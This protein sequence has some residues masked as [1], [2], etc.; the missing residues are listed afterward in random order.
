MSSSR[1]RLARQIS[2]LIE[3]PDWELLSD[4]SKGPRPHVIGVTG[5]PGAGKSTLVDQLIRRHVAAGD[6]PGVVVVDPSSPFTGGAIL[7]DRIRMQE[8]A[9]DRDVFIRSLANRGQLGGLAAGTEGVL[10]LLGREG[11]SPLLIETVGVGQ[12]EMDVADVADTVVL[13]LY[14]G[15]GDDVQ[16]AK[17]G[18]LETADVFF[19][20]KADRGDANAVARQLEGMLAMGPQSAW[21]PPILSGSALTGEGLDD[22]TT[23]LADHQATL[24]IDGVSRRERQRLSAFRRAVTAR[25][26]KAIEDELMDRVRKG[27]IDPYQ[28]A[29]ELSL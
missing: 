22:L 17:A 18:L 15:W 16:A 8:H 26:E 20:N 24:I 3:R 11:F 2:E 27:E 4:L 29:A 6:R 13:V 21:T 19:V 5:P 23:A 10:L 25:V 28:A 7:G 14:P 1:R 12:A 9:S